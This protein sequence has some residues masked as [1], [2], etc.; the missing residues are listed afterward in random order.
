MKRKCPKCQNT[1]FTERYSMKKN[2]KAILCSKCGEVL[3]KPEKIWEKDID[4]KY[5][6]D[7]SDRLILYMKN[8]KNKLRNK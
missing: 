6:I 7:I 4:D 2:K 1:S 8:N 3:S 5:N